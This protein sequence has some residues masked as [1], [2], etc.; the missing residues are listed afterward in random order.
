MLDQVGGRP[1]MEVLAFLELYC[2]VV[3]GMVLKV[4][5]EENHFYIGLTQMMR[6]LIHLDRY[7]GL[8]PLQVKLGKFGTNLYKLILCRYS[9]ERRYYFETFH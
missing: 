7:Q 2:K 8:L 5:E 4:E 6:W 9:D 1:W 3:W